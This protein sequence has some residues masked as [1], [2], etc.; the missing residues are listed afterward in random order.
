MPN[1]TSEPPFSERVAL[2]ESL[3]GTWLAVLTPSATLLAVI[4]GEA[5]SIPAVAQ[6]L[7]V[8]TVM[9]GGFGLLIRTQ[10]ARRRRNSDILVSF[11]LAEGLGLGLLAIAFLLLYV[12]TPS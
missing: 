8:V 12:H 2:R 10:F 3:R 4:V 9:F 7:F 6:W 11:V 5:L 1:T